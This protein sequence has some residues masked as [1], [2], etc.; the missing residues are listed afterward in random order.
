[1]QK[2]PMLTRTLGP[3]VGLYKAQSGTKWWSAEEIGPRIDCERKQETNLFRFRFLF[4][5][6]F[7]SESMCLFNSRKP[8]FPIVG[9]P[10]F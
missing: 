6:S 10:H 5:R 9:V 1:M 3:Q 2:V 8:T 4:C 7:R